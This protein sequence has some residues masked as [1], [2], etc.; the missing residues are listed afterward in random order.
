MSAMRLLFPG[1]ALRAIWESGL[2]VLGVVLGFAVSEW[3]SER[4]ARA[5]AAAAVERVVEELRANRHMIARVQPYH[6]AVGERLAELAASGG[7]A[8]P[9]IDQAIDAM[10][11]GVG[12][13]FLARAAWETAV[14]QGDLQQAPVPRTYEIARIYRLSELGVEQTWNAILTQLAAPE[15]YEPSP[16]P[17]QLRRMAASFQ[18]LASQE[19]FLIGEID[20]ILAALEADA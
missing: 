19:Q 1:W 6:A 12:D 15:A 2:I 8:R 16:S 3:R 7:D 9:L 10:P 5:D 18:E 14:A 11:S 4:Q 17:G 13:L 20:A